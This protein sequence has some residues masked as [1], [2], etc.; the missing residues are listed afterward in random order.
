[1]GCRIQT[2]FGLGENRNHGQ[3]A[4]AFCR[5]ERLPLPR[6]EA[7][8]QIVGGAPVGIHLVQQFRGKSS[9]FMFQF[10]FLSQGRQCGNPSSR[11]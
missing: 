11:S 10:A 3:E 6:A 4:F 8:R 9:V 5:V 2:P 1:V 7:D